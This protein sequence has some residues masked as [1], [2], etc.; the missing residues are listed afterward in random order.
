MLFGPL[1]LAHVDDDDYLD[2]VIAMAT[3]AVPTNGSLWLYP[4]SPDPLVFDT[5]PTLL[6]GSHAANDVLVSCDPQYYHWAAAVV[7]DNADGLY[8]VFRHSV[9]DPVGIHLVAL[10]LASPLP[11][12]PSLSFTVLPD[13]AESSLFSGTIVAAMGPASV[14]VGLGNTL[15]IVALPLAHPPP[16]L[17]ISWP[18]A[19]SAAT[20]TSL[21]VA[22]LDSDGALDLVVG[23]IASSDP[24]TG[25]LA[26]ILMS[27][28]PASLVPVIV[29]SINNNNFGSFSAPIALAPWRSPRPYTTTFAF[30]TVAGVFTDSAAPVVFTFDVISAPETRP[31]IRTLS[32]LVVIHQSDATMM[33]PPAFAVLP[34][35]LTTTSAVPSLLAVQCIVAQH[36]GYVL[37]LHAV[38]PPPLLSP[39]PLLLPSDLAAAKIP[40]STSAVVVGL[41]DADTEPDLV[42]LTFG[43]GIFTCIN[44]LHDLSQ[45]A[46]FRCITGPSLVQDAISSISDAAIALVDLT[47]DA[48]VDLLVAISAIDT[49]PGA[50][51]YAANLGHGVFAAPVAIK[52]LDTLLDATAIPG[53]LFYNAPIETL[54][55]AHTFPLYSLALLRVAAPVM[56][57]SRLVVT[58]VDL[59]V[60][61]SPIAVSAIVVARIAGSRPG[62]ADVVVADPISNAIVLVSNPGTPGLTWSSS[63]LAPA[64]GSVIGLAA[65][66]L[67]PPMPGSDPLDDIAI[68]EQALAPGGDFRV[69]VL[70][71]SQARSSPLQRILTLPPS[72][73]HTGLD[74]A[75][76][77]MLLVDPRNWLGNDIIALCKDIVVVWPSHGANATFAASFVVS[78]ATHLIL[79]NTISLALSDFDGNGWLDL[80]LVGFAQDG[81]SFDLFLHLPSPWL[82][83]PF[84][85]TF[86]AVPPNT[87][88]CAS[89]A[90]FACLALAMSR[91]S[92]CAV[93]TAVVT[94][95]FTGC[96]TSRHL[97]PS[98][99][100]VLLGDAPSAGIACSSAGGVVFDVAQGIDLTLT[101]LALSGASSIAAINGAAP[102]RIAGI[103][104]RLELHN[105]TVDAFFNSGT[106]TSSIRSLGVGYGGMALVLDGGTVVI[107]NSSISYCS[108][109]ASGGVVYAVSSSATSPSSVIVSNSY[110]S[111]NQAPNGATFAVGSHA[112]VSITASR[113]KNSLASVAGG[114]IAADGHGVNISVSGTVVEATAASIWGGVFALVPGARL[115]ATDNTYV[116]N[117][118]ILGGVLGVASRTVLDGVGYQS[119]F[120]PIALP[121]FRDIRATELVLDGAVLIANRAVYGSLVFACGASFSVTGPV[122]GS[123][124]SA[125][126]AGS[127]AMACPPHNASATITLADFVIAPP[128][129]LA[130]LGATSTSLTWGGSLA[131]S[132]IRLEWAAGIAALN[133]STV[134]SG[135]PLAPRFAL[136][137]Y[138]A[139]GNVITDNALLISL[140]LPSS[141]TTYG[142]SPDVAVSTTAN[143]TSLASLALA[144]T[145]HTVLDTDVVVT[146]VLKVSQAKSYIESTPIVIRLASCPGGRPPVRQPSGGLVCLCA[147][148]AELMPL[149]AD[150]SLGCGCEPEF[151]SPAVPVAAC[152]VCPP[153]GE[154]H[155]G[156]AR[157]RARE[158]YTPTGNPGF[159]LHCPEPEACIGDGA[160]IDGTEDRLCARCA[161]GWF[162]PGA[163]LGKCIRCKLTATG[164]IVVLAALGVI[165]VILLAAYILTPRGSSRRS[166]HGSIQIAL[167]NSS[168]LWV[169]LKAQTGKVKTVVAS[170][171]LEAGICVLLAVFG[172]AEA[173][174]V[175]AIACALIALTLYTIIDKPNKAEQA[176]AALK[177]M[178]VFLQTLSVVLG[179]TAA[180]DSASSSLATTRNMLERASLTLTG[181]G[182]I[183]AHQL[184]QF[185]VFVLLTAGPV[186][187][188]LVLRLVPDYAG[189]R[190]RA[191]LAAGTLGYLFVFP[192]IQ[193]SLAYFSCVPDPTPGVHA[194]Y[195]DSV[196]WVACGSREHIALIAS[197][198]T[199]LL[200]IAALVTVAITIARTAIAVERDG[201]HDEAEH[202]LPLLDSTG[203]HRSGG[204][205]HHH[206]LAFL[207]EAFRSQV[208][209]FEGV[210]FARRVAIAT[211][212]AVV[213][214]D[215]VFVGGGLAAVVALALGAHLRWHPLSDSR[216]MQLET[217]S[218]VA[219]L[220]VLRMV[221]M[222]DAA[223][224]ASTIESLAATVIVVIVAMLAYAVS[225][226][227]GSL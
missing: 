73:A 208:W 224:A 135:I 155:G 12:P 191:D 187:V 216:A 121:H 32:S 188:C 70:L 89:P 123:G 93:T 79:P 174:E 9:T 126:S 80:L 92:R 141:V 58:P 122:A 220:V 204:H 40:T 87:A 25:F 116:G 134:V 11:A 66:P 195:L 214:H 192:L 128:S 131:S 37:H 41:V 86:V 81:P 64:T 8:L 201:G 143:V 178:V 118:A 163:G 202:T 210:I 19:F 223:T 6:L 31:R 197:A 117:F 196:P 16:M 171:A 57:P 43:F 39:I 209:W 139:V 194:S 7:A 226:V 27:P 62:T 24:S 45:D 54:L 129:T 77:D 14:A 217:A 30:A 68:L 177:T 153:G 26:A 23:G 114:F 60:D 76:V 221:S 149:A 219:T 181:I 82:D 63:S 36:I 35:S 21:T 48:V 222:M 203:E 151:W 38:V 29:A 33:S 211:I 166:R 160:C 5:P 156:I 95:S 84:P 74:C 215:S 3:T 107:R 212:S 136:A 83:D 53:R 206:P 100:G 130:A 50:L 173:W 180:A 184:G 90:S 113:V 98:R 56:D 46:P 55:L 183:G 193:R 227:V 164:T 91:F 28:L 85:D 42:G 44:T 154:C 94:S 97:A 147:A 133:G 106:L 120:L 148:N 67:D 2:I 72:L 127:V 52:Q 142:G 190:R 119:N 172:L 158:G 34:A 18:A 49:R 138:D 200:A 124:N 167:A 170:L 65:G 17:P 168:T 88:A 69:R 1:L 10:H 140:V 137:I 146:A 152:V 145:D 61:L 169:R 101:S 132:P 112:K 179:S 213:P 161:P 198:L 96:P 78:A 144:A 125:S 185:W 225:V 115:V 159:F 75:V 182:C 103:D 51:L 157:P 110:L 207:W 111:N 104:A 176:E 4:G 218:L 47:G 105:T 22:D 108:A 186:V 150:G 99:S 205:S 175:V 165:V 71:S 15:T 189:N 20:I 102:L 162:A 199:V 109:S 13:T 59:G